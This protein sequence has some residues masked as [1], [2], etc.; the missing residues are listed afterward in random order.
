MTS[1]RRK[2]SAPPLV[3]K[4][5]IARVRDDDEAAELLLSLGEFLAQRELLTLGGRKNLQSGLSSTNGSLGLGLQDV[6]SCAHALAVD[7]W[8][9][10]PEGRGHWAEVAKKYFLQYDRGKPRRPTRLQRLYLD[11]S[12]DL[13]W[14]G[15]LQSCSTHPHLWSDLSQALSYPTDNEH[16]RRLLEIALRSWQEQGWGGWREEFECAQLPRA[17]L[18]VLLS[19]IPGITLAQRLEW[20]LEKGQTLDLTEPL[21]DWT[22]ALIRACS[23]KSEAEHSLVRKH[24]LNLRPL[25]R[26]ACRLLEQPG[27]VLEPATISAFRV[28]AT[29]PETPRR[30]E[31]SL[32]LESPLR[33]IRFGPRPGRCWWTEILKEIGSQVSTES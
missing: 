9:L 14:L 22:E 25:E 32:S 5:V 28:L 4:P 7:L 19:W 20:L 26:L 1:R 17:D 11:W 21:P 29:H 13:G 15:L 8:Q 6:R 31:Q 30:L 27:F 12:R 3:L 10:G 16:D 24:G 2:L 18:L 33:R 23:S